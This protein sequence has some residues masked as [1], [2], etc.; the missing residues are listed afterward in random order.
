M[1]QELARSLMAPSVSYRGKI[2]SPERWETWQP[3]KGDVLV[4]TPPKCGTTWTQTMAAMLL[5]GT[6]DLGAPVSVIS[7]WVDAALGA[8]DDVAKALSG[9]EGRRVVKTHTP[10]DGFPI[11]EGVALIAVY[12]HPL[13]V[14][15]SLRKHARN[16]KDN[17]DNP[18]NLP[19]GDAFAAF[20]SDP[21]DPDDFDRD[22]LATIVRHYDQTVLKKRYPDLVPFHYADMIS[23]QNATVRS[24]ARAI[25]CDADETLLSKV[26]T[27]TAFETMRADA[28]KY[29][30]EGGKGFWHDD[31]AFFDSGGAGKWH[32][33]ISENDLAKYRA[34]MAELVPDAKAR[35][36]LENGNGGALQ[37]PL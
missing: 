12:R 16:M 1:V 34:R 29:V 17:A 28:G 15:F 23:D 36:W 27:A 7:P 4:C 35:D 2:T 37:R 22:S 5:N 32:G 3:K 14:F 21:Y 9:Q 19:L 20:L 18:M 13:D 8:A 30:P 6:T 11:W 33:K 25:G 10:A 31:S 24:L 26:A